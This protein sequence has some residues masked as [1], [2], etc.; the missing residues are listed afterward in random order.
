[1]HNI[2][3]NA[4]HVMQGAF[5]ESVRMDLEE[6]Q[7]PPSLPQSGRRTNACFRWVTD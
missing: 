5:E 1:M 2:L 3:A 4:V 6:L 7:N